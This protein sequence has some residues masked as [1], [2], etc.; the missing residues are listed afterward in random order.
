MRQPLLQS[1]IRAPR[2]AQINQQSADYKRQKSY[3]DFFVQRV[4][5][6]LTTLSSSL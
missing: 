3:K 6:V 2:A 5:K 1:H 4:K